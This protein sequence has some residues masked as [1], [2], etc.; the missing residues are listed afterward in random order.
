MAILET[1]HEKKSMAITIVLHI[2]LIILLLLFG[3][4]Y[5]EPPL[6]K[7]IAVNLSLIHI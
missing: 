7:G 2:V 4:K 1:K 3:F 6:E 5:L